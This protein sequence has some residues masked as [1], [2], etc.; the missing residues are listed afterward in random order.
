MVI[1]HSDGVEIVN[2]LGP[3]LPFHDLAHYVVESNLEY[4]DGLFG[5]LAKGYSI[6]DLSSKEVIK[7]L[8]E[9]IMISEVASRA[10][11]GIVTG[12]VRLDQFNLIVQEELDDMDSDYSFSI[13]TI[14]IEKM[15][16]DYEGLIKEWQK[17]PTGGSLEF[18]WP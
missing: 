8:P 2:D 5:N 9:Q 12:S 7:I 13:S 16:R 17:L 1:T 15:V 3:N 10:L 18:R 14:V 11:S 6:P 4:D